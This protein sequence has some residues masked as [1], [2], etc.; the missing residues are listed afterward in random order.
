MVI[1]VRNNKSGMVS[2]S[3][4]FYFSFFVNEWWIRVYFSRESKKLRLSLAL[5]ILSPKLMC[6]LFNDT[7][8]HHVYVYKRIEQVLNGD[9][10][11]IKIHFHFSAW[12][13]KLS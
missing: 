1:P 7:R 11:P 4:S 10:R 12:S 8:A 6:W 3:L 5:F 9:F 2:L 13:I